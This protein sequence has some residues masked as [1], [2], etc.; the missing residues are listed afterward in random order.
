MSDAGG[1]EPPLLV[2]EW[3]PGPTPATHDV[4]LTAPVVVD[5]GA[6]AVGERTPLRWRGLPDQEVERRWRDLFAWVEWLLDAFDVRVGRVENGRWWRS[7]GAVEELSAL[8]DWHRELVDVTIAAPAPD[9]DELRGR[10]EWIAHER[11]ERADRC[12]T[13][14]DL[15][16]WH[17]AR[18][19]VCARLIPSQPQELLVSRGQLTEDSRAHQVEMRRQRE[20]EFARF[21]EDGSA[22]G[23]SPGAD[24]SGSW[25]A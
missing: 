4:A 6:P 14:R 17:D 21:L 15:V 16:Y 1:D 3:R 24:G 18:A 7:P 20:E 12:S 22:P 23:L 9:E 19:R 25:R 11:G 13:A 5:H 8:R 2:E 10:A